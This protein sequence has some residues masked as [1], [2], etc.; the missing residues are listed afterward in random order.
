MSDSPLA[1]IIPGVPSLSGGEAAGLLVAGVCCAMWPAFVLAVNAPRGSAPRAWPLVVGAIGGCGA[2]GPGLVLWA[3]PTAAWLPLGLHALWVALL[4]P[5]GLADFITR[6]ALVLAGRTTTLRRQRLARWALDALYVWPAWLLSSLYL[7][8][9]FGAESH[10][11]TV[12]CVA[13]ALFVGALTAGRP[14]RRYQPPDAQPPAPAPWS[15]SQRST[16]FATWLLAAG[17]AFGGAATAVT[18]GAWSVIVSLSMPA[19]ASTVGAL[20]LL[21]LIAALVADV[22]ERRYRVR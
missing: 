13:A 4:V 6:A 3:A 12:V 15:W 20:A 17:L 16:Q 19:G 8:A 10:V 9:A 2:L 22:A 11:A 18:L 21:A 5:V 7:G 14:L 1:V